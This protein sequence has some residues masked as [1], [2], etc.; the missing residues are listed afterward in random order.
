[1]KA[2]QEGQSFQISQCQFDSSLFCDSS[3]C[4]LQQ[5]GQGWFGVYAHSV[6]HRNERVSW[7]GRVGDNR[8]TKTGH[9]AECWDTL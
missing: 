3:M 5:Q 2:S 8:Q 1:M 9:S 7:S 6:T 4:C